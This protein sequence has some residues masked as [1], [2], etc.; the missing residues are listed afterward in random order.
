MSRCRVEQDEL[1]YDTKQGAWESVQSL[2]E[3]SEPVEELEPEIIK[4]PGTWRK[5]GNTEFYVREDK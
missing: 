1:D 2:F 3:Y 5:V 4:R